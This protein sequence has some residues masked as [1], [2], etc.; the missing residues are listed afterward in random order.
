MG[1]GAMRPRSGMPSTIGHEPRRCRFFTCITVQCAAQVGNL[2]LRG[3]PVCIASR[4]CR[5]F[6]C[7][8]VPC[9]AQVGNLRLRGGPALRRG[10]RLDGQFDSVDH[11]Q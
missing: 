6:T 4:R 7:I 9:A 11:W 8:T 10:F 2:R 5:F 1:V 3:G